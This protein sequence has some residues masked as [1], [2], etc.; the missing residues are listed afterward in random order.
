MN[1]IGIPVIPNLPPSNPRECVSAA[2]Y[3]VCFYPGFVRR[4][5][6]VDEG[7]KETPVYEQRLPFVLPAGQEK[8]WPSSTIEVR[9]NGASVMVQVNDTD[10]QVDSIE[11]VLKARDGSGNKVRLVVEDGPVLC[12][13][14]CEE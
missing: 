2:G 7:G 11:I 9:G 3:E 14:F 6:L 5:V 8:P 12:P 10:Q 13:P 1:N 4:L